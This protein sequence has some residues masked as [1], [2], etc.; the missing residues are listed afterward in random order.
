MRVRWLIAA[1]VLASPLVSA[2]EDGWV[3]TMRSRSG[4]RTGA[5]TMRVNDDCTSSSSKPEGPVFTCSGEWRCRGP[6]CPGRRGSLRIW[7]VGATPTHVFLSRGRNAHVRTC[8]ANFVGT[9]FPGYDVLPL[10]WT[11]VCFA[12]VHP[13]RS[14]ATGSFTLDLA[15]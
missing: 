5:V 15:R 13:T 14:Y 2:A 1:L 3:A 6:A 4:H 8:A 7:R 12:G 10:R 11:Y 9:P